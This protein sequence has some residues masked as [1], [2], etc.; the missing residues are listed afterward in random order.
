MK[1]LGC[2]IITL[3]VTKCLA[4]NVEQSTT[5]IHPILVQFTNYAEQSRKDWKVPGMAIAIVK[6]DKVIYAKGFGIRNE[7][8]APVTADTIFDI[9]SLTKS[10]TATL[11]AIQIDQGKYN[12][13]TKITTLYPQ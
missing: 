10:F 3:S 11:L 4:I 8:K 7:K 2:L 9:A 5:Q 6:N 12:W 13:D 1:L